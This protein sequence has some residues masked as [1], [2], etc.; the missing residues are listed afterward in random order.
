MFSVSV[1]S[2]MT[3]DQPFT[4]WAA[5]CSVD[6]ITSLSVKKVHTGLV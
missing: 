5:L 6:A 4:V 2:V 3:A 1:L